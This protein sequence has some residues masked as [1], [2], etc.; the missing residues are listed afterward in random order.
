MASTSTHDLE[1]RIILILGG[2]SGIGYGVAIASLR[3]GAAVVTVASSSPE[4]VKKAVDRLNQ[5][6]H[7]NLQSKIQGIVKGVVID[8]KDL[9]SVETVIKS[10][11]TIDHLVFTSGDDIGDARGVNIRDLD[12]ENVKG[13]LERNH[14][15]HQ[16]AIVNVEREYPTHI[17]SEQG[18][19]DV[20]FWAAI[21][22]AK[23]ARFT[24]GGSVT[25]TSGKHP[26]PPCPFISN[27][28]H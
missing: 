15:P 7:C 13:T 2:T 9:S 27:G 16:T 21:Q 28:I 10:L 24:P 14:Y 26:N 23:S 25:L 12:I 5:Q 17:S 6:V 19:F 4:K 18:M 11:G 3:A 22:A 8:G 20:R 1:G